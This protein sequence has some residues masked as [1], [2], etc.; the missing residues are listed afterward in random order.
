MSTDFQM[1]YHLG[2]DN[3]HVKMVHFDGNPPTNC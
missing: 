2:S 3:L 1:N